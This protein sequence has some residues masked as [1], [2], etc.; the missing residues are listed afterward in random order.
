MKVETYNYKNLG[1]IIDPESD[2]KVRTV[3]LIGKQTVK[4]NP[5]H[6]MILISEQPITENCEKLEELKT[7]CAENKIMVFCPASSEISSMEAVY[8][9]LFRE[10]LEFNILRDDMLA[11]AYDEASLERAVEFRE[12]IMDEYD[13]DLG[14]IKV[15][16]V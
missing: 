6:A 16:A 7:Y 4:C 10:Y 3:I 8:K 12:Y 11:A 14:K 1:F 9:E 15:L 13:A 5:R 2:T